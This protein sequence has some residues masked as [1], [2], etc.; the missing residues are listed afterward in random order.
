MPRLEITTDEEDGVVTFTV[1]L[2]EKPSGG[3]E[4]I[5]CNEKVQKEDN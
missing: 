3:N 2:S 1:E 5:N 4:D